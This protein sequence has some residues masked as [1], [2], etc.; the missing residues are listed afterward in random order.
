LRDMG[1]YFEN[2]NRQQGLFEGA[3]NTKTANEVNEMIDFITGRIEELNRQLSLPKISLEGMLRDAFGSPLED[4]QAQVQNLTRYLEILKDRRDNLADGAPIV[5]TG[6]TPEEDKMRAD[7]A[8][9]EQEF[10]DLLTQANQ[11]KLLEDE[12]NLRNSY[13]MQH[14]LL[15]QLVD[16]NLK[17]TERY[18]MAKARIEQKMTQNTMS[19]L[20]SG[21]SALGQYNRKAFAIGKAASIASAVINTYEGATKALA[22]YAPPW[23]F[24]MAAAQVASGMAQ[25]AQIKSQSFSGRAVGGPVTAGEPF[26]VGEQGRELFVPSQNGQIIKN[27]DLGGSSGQTNI[28]FQ[29]T[30]VD[31]TGFDDL[32]TSRRAMIVGMINR[33]MNEKGRPGIA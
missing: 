21:F 26:M 13:A 2:I 14:E 8:K 27:S 28:S 25:V 7:K 32:L 9:V 6:T 11:A 10:N 4:I 23:S 19:E 12:Y 3:L 15:Q 1:E 24:A 30:T 29:I 16:S 31:A 18:A 22:T 33:A 5:I 17:E 20:A